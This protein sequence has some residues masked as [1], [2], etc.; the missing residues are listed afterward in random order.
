[1]M[2]GE[3]MKR[4]PLLSEPLLLDGSSQ[5]SAYGDSNRQTASPL[6]ENERIAPSNEAGSEI[7]NG[8]MASSGSDQHRAPYETSN[9][10]VSYEKLPVS[11]PVSVKNATSRPLLHEDEDNEIVS[12]TG[13][14]G[15]KALDRRGRQRGSSRVYADEGEAFT[16]TVPQISPFKSNITADSDL[17]TEQEEKKKLPP[18]C[19][20][21]AYLIHL[22]VFGILGVLTRYFLQKL[23]GPSVVGVTSDGSI[24]YL[25]LPSNMVGSF[26]MGWLGVVFK[27][28]ISRFSDQLATGLSTG[29][30]GSL[31]TFSGW[32]QKMLD[33]SVNGHWVLAVLGFVV[34]LILAAGSISF[35]VETAKGFGWLL[36]RVKR[37][38]GIKTSK[39]NKYNCNL[40]VLLVLVLMWAGLWTTSGILEKKEF[41]DG[42]SGA[43]LWLACFVG[44]V[45]V[46]VRWWLARLNG[47]GLGRTGRWNWFPFGT[48]IANVS[49]ACMMAALSTVKKAVNTTDCDTVATGLQFGLMGCLS[50]VSTLMAEYNALRNSSH[51]WRAYAYVAVTI[52]VSFGLGTL[53][54]SVPVWIK[55]YT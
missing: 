28:N 32:N 47:Q 5:D 45:G 11:I 42:G 9:L 31:T 48:L 39:I 34:G 12:Q 38:F 18:L 46:W 29:Y 13:D 25:D 43:Q 10:T 17:C 1:M 51:P 4:D 44:P 19:E 23:F 3:H 54:Y 52:G 14:S 36:K 20:C 2:Q 26:L 8:R 21:L 27:G 40:V 7:V 15:D 24:L 37:G 49:A 55:G 35:G 50:T 22:A 30:L 41:K 6:K 53:I 33:L 16:V